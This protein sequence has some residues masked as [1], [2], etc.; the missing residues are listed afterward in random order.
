MGDGRRLR[1]CQS[2]DDEMDASQA[3][4]SYI[5]IYTGV[6]LWKS[7]HTCHPIVTYKSAVRMRP[8]RFWR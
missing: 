5:F 1:S 8:P 7:C 6:A 2:G 4:A 3:A